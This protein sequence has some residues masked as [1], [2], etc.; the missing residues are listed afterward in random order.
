MKNEVSNRVIRL[1]RQVMDL[2]RVVIEAFHT[3]PVTGEVDLGARLIP[4]LRTADRSGQS[5]HRAAGR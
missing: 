5:A 4:G 2:I 1:P 3:D